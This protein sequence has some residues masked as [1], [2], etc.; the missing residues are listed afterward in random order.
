LDALVRELGSWDPASL[1]A[2]TF[3]GIILR[4]LG[5]L[6]TR[7]DQHGEASSIAKQ[8]G[9]FLLESLVRSLRAGRKISQVPAEHAAVLDAAIDKVSG[10]RAGIY[11]APDVESLDAQE[12][13][14]ED[15]MKEALQK[16]RG[17]GRLA[18]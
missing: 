1:S 7:I 16:T 5:T 18:P 14:L 6:R 17:A 2:T 9:L 15:F 11:N 12:R 10:T 13:G 3:S 4:F 8:A